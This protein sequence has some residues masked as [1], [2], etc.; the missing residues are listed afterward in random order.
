MS[1][2]RGAGELSPDG[3]ELHDLRVEA[4]QLRRDQRETTE[5]M[6]DAE[7]RS[8]ELQVELLAARRQQDG[9]DASPSDPAETPGDDE[10]GVVEGEG[11]RAALSL[12]S[13][14]AQTASRKKGDRFDK[15]AG[16]GQ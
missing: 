10:S 16:F 15:D 4:Q 3:T 7:R 12:R 9:I 1:S 14:L 5:R 6:R 8:A 13:R 11:T 2:V